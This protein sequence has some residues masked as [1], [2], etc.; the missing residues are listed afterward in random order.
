MNT[1]RWLRCVGLRWWCRQRGGGE[2]TVALRG[3]SDVVVRKHTSCY[4]ICAAQSAVQHGQLHVEADWCLVSS[5]TFPFIRIRF[6][7]NPC[8]HCRSVTPLPFPYRVPNRN[9]KIEP[10]PIWRDERKQQT[11]GNGERYFYVSYGILTDERNSYVFLKRITE[12]RLRINAGNQA[13]AAARG[14]RA[15]A[16]AA[17]ADNDDNEEE[18]D[19][20]AKMCRL[21]SPF[22][23][24]Q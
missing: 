23:V 11:Y 6:R 24:T 9:G 21:F 20:D 19:D 4:Y 16:A 17:A 10:I 18:D 22:L 15:A 5:I 2:Q 1:W 12:I 14:R 7:N 13:W 8:P 3:W